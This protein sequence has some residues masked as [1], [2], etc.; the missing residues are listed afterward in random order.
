L[1]ILLLAVPC[2][3]TAAHALAQSCEVTKLLPDNG[4]ASDHF[5]YSVDADGDV[6]IVGAPQSSAAAP[7][8]GVAYVFRS[9]DGVWSQEQRLTASDAA[10]GDRFG[11]RVAVDGNVAVV[12]A[13]NHDGGGANA[14]AAYVFEFNGAEWTEPITLEAPAAEASRF[15]GSAV[16]VSGDAIAV[17][18]PGS[19]FLPQFPGAVD[20]FERTE[21]VWTHAQTLTASDAEG[22]DQF[23]IALSLDGD[24]LCVGA[25]END[26]AGSRS[27]SAYIF[28][29]DAGVWSESQKL[30][31]SDAGAFDEFGWSVAIDSQHALIGAYRD[32]DAGGNAGAAYAFTYDGELWTEAHKL[33]AGEVAE[34]DQFGFSLDIA[35]DRAVISAWLDDDGGDAAGAVYAYQLDTGVWTE[36]DKLVAHDPGIVD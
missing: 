28:H 33:I 25:N 27:G 36:R 2:G 18:S 14:G 1:L 35:G 12:G 4:A 3:L 31:A 11:H 34:L 30:T 22:R 10:E 21:G 8:A 20:V 23:G 17:G 16:A 29:R 15:F 32:D 13:V 19:L 9:I 5:G 26:D 24:T 7:N 6:L